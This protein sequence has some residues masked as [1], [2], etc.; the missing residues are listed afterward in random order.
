[1]QPQK[2]PL[3][4]IDNSH[5]IVR[6]GMAASLQQAGFAIR[7][8]SVGLM[9]VPTVERLDVLL[10]ESEGSAL[11]R[12]VR[13]VKGSPTRLVATIRVNSSEASAS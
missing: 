5:A 4:W 12:A 8:E 3:V 13:L 6:R 9:P 11:R 2:P 7:G 10:F 1:M